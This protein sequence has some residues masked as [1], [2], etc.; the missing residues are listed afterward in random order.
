MI[1]IFGLEA[2]EG[3]EFTNRNIILDFD[4]GKWSTSQLSI[5]LTKVFKDSL[6]ILLQLKIF[7]HISGKHENL[8]LRGKETQ[9]MQR[10]C[11]KEGRVEDGKAVADEQRS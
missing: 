9:K 5:T 11:S 4:I 7:D 6:A 8:Q 10:K 1:R 3:E 2:G